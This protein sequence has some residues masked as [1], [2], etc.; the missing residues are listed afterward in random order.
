MTD[1]VKRWR[2]R[3]R[4]LLRA[5]L[6]TVIAAFL[7]YVTAYLF[8][9]PHVADSVHITVTSHGLSDS[10]LTVLFDKT[11]TDAS[12]VGGVADT[13]NGLPCMNRLSNISC[14]VS[15]LGS[16]DYEYSFRFFWHGIMLQ[17][18]SVTYGACFYWDVVTLGL[19]TLAAHTDIRGNVIGLLRGYTDL[20][21]PVIPPA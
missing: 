2:V 5:A 21:V 11:F 10:N 9:A 1:R 8:I 18:A 20:P 13:I 17:R 7:L 12:T 14:P 4:R 16:T 15:G 6:V 19:P 3:A